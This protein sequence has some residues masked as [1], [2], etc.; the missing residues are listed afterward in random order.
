MQPLASHVPNIKN[1]MAESCD[2]LR[3]AFPTA[4]ARFV[5]EIAGG[6]CGVLSGVDVSKKFVDVLS[7]FVLDCHQLSVFMG[8]LRESTGVPH[9]A[10][11][12]IL[13]AK[14]PKPPRNF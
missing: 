4:E 6:S 2:M 5:C 10:R 13:P 3:P 8:E 12:C 9:Y 7:E 1:S 11:C 14:E